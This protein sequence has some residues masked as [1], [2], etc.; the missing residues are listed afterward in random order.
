[1]NDFNKWFKHLMEDEGGYVN[2][3]QDPGGETKYGVSKRA[4][5]NLVINS[6]T[7]EQAADIAKQD[8]WDKFPYLQDSMLK[9]LVA[10]TAFNSGTERAEK[11]LQEALGV[12]VDGQVGPQ[13]LAALEMQL[14]AYGDLYVATAFSMHRLLFFADLKTFQRFG[15]G[16][17]RRVAL[18]VLF[19]MRN[20]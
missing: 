14:A 9:C 6:V 19:F 3:P 18:G 10:D 5:P 20:D 1:M 12:G 8:Y 17:S 2:D 7:L 13:T 11:L 16:W 15:R 4:Y